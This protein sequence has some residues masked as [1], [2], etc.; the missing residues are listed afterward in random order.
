MLCKAADTEQPAAALAQLG[1]GGLLGYYA[2]HYFALAAVYSAAADAPYT[3]LFL[4]HCFV[5]VHGPSVLFQGVPA[6]IP[7]SFADDAKAGL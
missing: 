4:L 3:A 2:M 6:S 5:S 7:L 1:H